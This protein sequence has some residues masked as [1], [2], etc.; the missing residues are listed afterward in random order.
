MKHA[1]E[2]YNRIQDPE[3][4]I[5]EDEPVFLIRAQ[6]VCGPGT[7]SHWAMMAELFGAD[8]EVVEAARRQAK[9]MYEWH[10]KHGHKVPDTP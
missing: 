7:V 8:P 5:P 9:E 2:D 10:R 6:D 4:L 1:R 3:G